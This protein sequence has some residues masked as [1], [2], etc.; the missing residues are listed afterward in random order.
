MKAARSAH[1]WLARL[2]DVNDPA[3]LAGWGWREL[4]SFGATL[5]GR[6]LRGCLWK[7]R[8]RH[9]P[10][11]VLCGPRVVIHHPWHVSVGSGL[12]LEEGCELVGL[13]K[14]GLVFGNRCTVGRFAT[15]RPTNVLLDVPGEGLR[16]GDRS[17]IGAYSYIGCS[18]FIDVGDDVLMGP[19]VSLLAENHRFE[20]P[21]LPIKAQGVERSFIRIEDN[22]WIGASATILAGVTVH[23]GAVIAAGAVVTTDV[24]ANAVVGGV[25]ARVI[26]TRGAPDVSNARPDRSTV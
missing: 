20:D 8:L 18:G 5:G 7:L 11:L 21:A 15:I 6:I 19:R 2:K 4:V 10:G 25:P 24:P 26:K 9:A 3:A 12:N 16:M 23:S 14:R 17:N 1:R 13:A 22:C